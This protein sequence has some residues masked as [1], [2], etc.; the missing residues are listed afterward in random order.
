MLK[1]NNRNTTKGCEICSS[2]RLEKPVGA[3]KGVNSLKTN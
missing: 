1:V 2:L 3:S